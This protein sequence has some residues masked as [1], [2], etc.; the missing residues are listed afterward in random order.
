MKAIHSSTSPLPDLMLCFNEQVKQLTDENQLLEKELA[1][2]S[3]AGV[4]FN[5][6][7][8]ETTFASGMIDNAGNSA[9]TQ[10]IFNFL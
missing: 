1:A 9:F 4:S 2:A 3:N 10:D 6:N 8:Q 7:I 5:Q